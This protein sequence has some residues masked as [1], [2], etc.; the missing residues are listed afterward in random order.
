MPDAA[1]ALPGDWNRASRL[2]IACLCLLIYCIGPLRVYAQDTTLAG[3]VVDQSGKAIPNAAVVLRSEAGAVRNTTTDGEGHFSVTGLP[4]GTYTAE[5]SSPGFSQASRTGIQLSAGVTQDVSISLSVA[6]VATTVNVEAVVSV[7]AQSAPL[8]AQLEEESPHAEISEPYIRNFTS[9]VTDFTNVLQMTPGTFSLSPNGIGLGQSTVYFRGFPDG[10]YTMTYDGIPFEDTNTPTHHSWSFFPGQWIGGVDFDRSPGTASTMGPSNFGGSINLL[11]RE[12]QPDPAIQAT[13]SYGSWD[14]RLLDMTGNTGNFGNGK[15]TLWFDVHQME[16]SGYQTFNKQKRDG[17]SIKYQYRLSPKTTLTLFTGI[18]DLWTNTPNFGG[19]TRAQIAQFGDNYLLSGNPSDPNWYGYNYYHVQTNFDYFGV[20]SDLGGGWK[21]DDKLY[22]Y[23]YWNK[24]NYNSQTSFSTPTS[25]SGVDKL[26]GYTKVGDL[27]TLS[28][29]SRWG[30]FRAGAW[31]EW[32]YTDRYQIP[33]NPV[34][35]VDALLPNFHEH[36]ITQSVQPFVEYALKATSRLTITA[37]IK[38]AYYHMALDQYQDNGKIAGCVGGG[39]LSTAKATPASTCI[40]GTQFVGHAAGYNSWLPALSANYHLTRTWSVYGQ[41]ARGSIIPP[42]A[43]FDQPGGAVEVIPKP[44]ITNTYQ[45]GTVMRRNRFTADL[46]AY[47]SRFQNT[48]AS[49]VDPVTTLPIYYLTPDTITKGVEAEGNVFIGWGASL[50]ANVTAGNAKYVGSGLWV[51]DT[52]RNTQ[53]VGLSY[54][55]KNWDVAIFDKRIGQMYND[56]GS[57]HEAV[58][59]NPF[60]LTD[61]YINY[62]LKNSSFLRNS[63]I[64]LSFN[65]L[66]DNHNIVAVTPAST[67]TAAPSPN[68]ILVLL[69]GRSIMLTL[70]VGYAPKR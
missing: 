23:H 42:S 24:Q 66:F 11:S 49:Y 70:T 48:Y 35:T 67:S 19:A 27:I 50:Y 55:H 16:S 38:P 5:A 8:Q 20:K 68:D 57:T 30:T 47:Y 28:Q 59:I 53:A 6:N 58:T 2:A 36:F 3:T 52:P 45:T 13:I 54:Q 33:E 60:S 65:N 63:K 31:Y 51:Q 39:V 1:L 9:P 17:G 25:D 29:E 22:S 40:G 32:A 69:P 21:F 56:N 44:V 64:G 12:T 34:T 41:Y 10:D 15:S 61:F 4:V 26:N 18:I 14:T 7:A 43:V 37:G 46:D 62:T